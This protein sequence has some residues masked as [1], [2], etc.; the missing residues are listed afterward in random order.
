MDRALNILG[1]GGT[2]GFLTVPHLVVFI[3]LAL[4]WRAVLVPI[5]YKNLHIL[6]HLTNMVLGTVQLHLL[7]V[8]KI[9][10]LMHRYQ[11]DIKLL[12]RTKEK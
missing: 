1:G 12:S 8:G 7:T 9:Q 4:E 3:P 6:W 11:V 2:Y 10:N 5:S